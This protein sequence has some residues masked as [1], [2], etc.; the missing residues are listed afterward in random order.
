MREPNELTQKQ[1]LENMQRV[2]W[3]KPDGTKR[4]EMEEF[5]N[6]YLSEEAFNWHHGCAKKYRPLKWRWGPYT[7]R[8]DRNRGPL[9]AYFGD[10]INDWRCISYKK[11]GRRLSKENSLKEDI[12]GFFREI[13][14]EYYP[15]KT[16]CG[17]KGPHCLVDMKMHCH[18]ET[19]SFDDMLNMTYEKIKIDE[20]D[21]INNE[22]F[23]LD[24]DNE[25]LIFFRNLCSTCKVMW[26]CQNCHHEKHGHIIKIPKPKK[27][28]DIG[29]LVTGN[30]FKN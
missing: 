27:E 12:N 15:F 14:A 9:Q 30:L 13:A 25:A 17:I 6:E 7:G 3:Y 23:H 22:K 26:L 11:I 8:S 10:P 18:H 20:Y 1:R 5:T 24:E 4:K 2:V 19:W 16:K 29:N 21:W 28:D